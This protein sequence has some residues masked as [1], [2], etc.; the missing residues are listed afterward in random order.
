MIYL[1]SVLLIWAQASFFQEV[2]DDPPKQVPSSPW[3]YP[4]C[5]I[6]SW[7]TKG[8]LLT[9]VMVGIAYSL[10]QVFNIFPYLLIC[11]LHKS[12]VYTVFLLPNRSTSTNCLRNI[13]LI[14]EVNSRCTSARAS[15]S[16][17]RAKPTLVKISRVNSSIHLEMIPTNIYGKL[18]LTIITRLKTYWHFIKLTFCT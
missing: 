1:T 6:R 16:S 9:A 17:Q 10:T 18:K 5:I 7:I 3:F 13:C 14:I 11:K 4:S 15:H 12:R 8:L 2:F